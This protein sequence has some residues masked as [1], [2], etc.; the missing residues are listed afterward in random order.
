MKTTKQPTRCQE[1]DLELLQDTDLQSHPVHGG[2]NSVVVRH[3]FNR[4]YGGYGRAFVV[5]VMHANFFDD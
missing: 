2:S 3:L 5:D 4:S 1:F